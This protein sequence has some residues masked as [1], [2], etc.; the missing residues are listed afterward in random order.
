MTQYSP[1]WLSQG[2][3]AIGMRPLGVDYVN[4]AARYTAAVFKAQ[5]A[6]AKAVSGPYVWVY[7]HGSAW[8]QMTQA[9]VDQYSNNPWHYERSGERSAGARC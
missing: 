1:N 7:S 8:W 2:S 4:K 9:E 6:Q 5:L 3:L